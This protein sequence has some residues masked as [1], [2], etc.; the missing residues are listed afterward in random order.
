MAGIG[1]MKYKDKL[2]LGPP[3]DGSTQYT[4]ETGIDVSEANYTVV[5]EDVINSIILTAGSGNIDVGFEGGGRAIL[6]VTVSSG[7]IYPSL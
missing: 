7:D 3:V 1:H 2:L 4:K 5:G 6:P